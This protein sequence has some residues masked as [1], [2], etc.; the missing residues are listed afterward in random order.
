MATVARTKQ[1]VDSMDVKQRLWDSMQN[2]YGVKKE[3]TEQAY[4]KAI[5]QADR[6]ALSRGMQRSSYNNQ[7]LGNL[8]NQ[9]AKALGDIDSEMIADYENRLQQIEEAEA[10]RAF[11]TSEREAQQKWQS[12]EN[13]LA[14]AFQTGEREATQIYNTS[15]RESQQTWQGQQNELARA[16]QTSERLG[17]QAWQSGENALARAEQ[18]RQFDENMAYNREQAAISNA[19]N[20]ATL[21]ETIRSNDLRYGTG[22]QYAQSLAVNWVQS[23]L[24]N[25]QMPSD[26]MLAQA[27]LSRADAE[28]LM[29]K[30]SSGGGSRNTTPPPGEEEGEGANDIVSDDALLKTL[31]AGLSAGATTS[32]PVNSLKGAGDIIDKYKKKTTQNSTK[33]ISGG[34]GS[35][36]NVV[37]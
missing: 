22:G 30:T 27:G 15:E 18:G 11:Q 16:F 5:S 28:K 21:Q 4:D 8:N 7:V 9:R 35:S 17:Q 26:D 1:D 33:G 19:L 24:A 29:A 37:R 14:R 12:E 34:P 10:A 3:N 6:Q 23:M 32:V 13:A 20:Q 25:G 2:S 36:V 31:S